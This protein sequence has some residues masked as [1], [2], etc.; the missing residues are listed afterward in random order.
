MLLCYAALLP[1]MSPT[2]A[3]VLPCFRYVGYSRGPGYYPLPG[4]TPFKPIGTIPQVPHTFKYFDSTYG[5]M[6]EHQVGVAESTCS[7]I[8]STVCFAALCYVL[9]GTY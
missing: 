6:N 3:T 7:G 1:Y 8:F 9:H 2:Y 4:Q 5:I